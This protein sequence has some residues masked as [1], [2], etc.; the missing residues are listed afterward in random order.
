M[1][2]RGSDEIS[3]PVAVHVSD[4]SGDPTELIFG[5]LAVPLTNDMDRLDKRIGEIGLLRKEP[6]EPGIGSQRDEIGI[7]RKFRHVVTMRVACALQ[8]LERG[9]GTLP[10]RIRSSEREVGRG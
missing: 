9:V 6:L 1:R 2:W 7:G 8:P 3:D 5:R 10:G 4:V